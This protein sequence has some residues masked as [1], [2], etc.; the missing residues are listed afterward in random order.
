M[1]STPQKMNCTEGSFQLPREQVFPG[2]SEL[3]QGHFEFNVLSVIENQY[4][5]Q[6]SFYF[7]RPS[8]F[9]W[10]P[11]SIPWGPFLSYRP[12]GHVLI[13]H[14]SF[15]VLWETCSILWERFAA[16]RVIFNSMIPKM[17][18]LI[19][20]PMHFTCTERRWR[21]WQLCCN[22]QPT[23][24]TRHDSIKWSRVVDSIMQVWEKRSV[25]RTMSI[26][27]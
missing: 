23:S 1:D 2:L 6:T 3:P 7:S 9:P 25:I 4:S 22:N 11:V 5:L 10:E 24:L 18:L 17:A 12:R 21:N 15:T 14:V 27:V 16:P 8:P 19:Q 20:D 13:Y 26:S